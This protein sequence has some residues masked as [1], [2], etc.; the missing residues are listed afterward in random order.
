MIKEQTM[1]SEPIIFRRFCPDDLPE[2]MRIQSANLIPNLSRAEQ[3]DGFLSAEFSP[4]QFVHMDREIP[5]IV[6][7]CGSRLGG[8]L[9][10]CSL[11]SCAKVPLLAHMA[12]LLPAT[13]Y[14]SKPVNQYGA[15]I[16]GPVCVDRPMRG[17]GILEGLFRAY[18]DQ[19]A[20]K[21]DIGILFVSLDNPRSLRAHIHKLGMTKLRNFSF[22]D[23]DYALLVFDLGSSPTKL[24]KRAQRSYDPKG[25]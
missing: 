15:F 8:Y 22:N 17:K 23:R 12:A 24:E 10:G 3:T 20:G 18:K 9:C 14:R 25:L 5:L 1:T 19:L 13:M 2:I 7:D 4:D 16:Y 11:A 21:F 6:A